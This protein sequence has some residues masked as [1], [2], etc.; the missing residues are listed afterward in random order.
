MPSILKVVFINVGYEYFFFLFALV[1]RHVIVCC[2][3]Q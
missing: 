3:E 2:N 1:D